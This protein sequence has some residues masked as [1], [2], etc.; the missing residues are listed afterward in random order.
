MSK[1]TCMGMGMTY[2]QDSTMIVTILHAR[3]YNTITLP[4]SW[5][6]ALPVRTM[7]LDL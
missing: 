3:V 4:G 6:P 1:D 7:S 2:E 5:Y